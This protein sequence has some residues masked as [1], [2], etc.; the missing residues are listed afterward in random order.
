MPEWPDQPISPTE[1]MEEFVPAALAE[2]E[3]PEEA[4]VKLGVR[5]DGEEGGE[6]LVTFRKGETSVR[7]TTR[8]EAVLTLIQTVED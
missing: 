3:I 7:R 1:F 2:T 5:L 4:D 8:E 6:W